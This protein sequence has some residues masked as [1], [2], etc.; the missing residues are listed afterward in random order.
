MQLRR[1]QGGISVRLEMHLHKYN[2]K[3]RDSESSCQLLI[4]SGSRLRGLQ[5][6]LRLEKTRPLASISAHASVR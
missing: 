3:M 1:V 4:P 5:S 6:R 2:V